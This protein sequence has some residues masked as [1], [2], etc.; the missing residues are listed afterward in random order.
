M[1]LPERII[2]RE[3]EV[4]GLGAILSK[5]LNVQHQRIEHRERHEQT[6]R[7]VAAET[8]L[9]RGSVDSMMSPPD[10]P[11]MPPGPPP[12]P[13]PPGPRHP[14]STPSRGPQGDMGPHGPP[15][16]QGPQGPQGPPGAPGIGMQGPP[17]PP[18]PPTPGT[19]SDQ[20]VAA[21][22]HSSKLQEDRMLAAL[23]AQHAHFIEQ[24]K[25]LEARM[26]L[27]EDI[28]MRATA[29]TTTEII[30]EQ[31][32]GPPTHVHPVIA[33]PENDVQTQLGGV[34]VDMHRTLS[35]H[36]ARQAGDMR[37]FMKQWLKEASMWK[38]PPQH[39]PLTPLTPGSS[40]GDRKP[41]S[42]T[43]SLATQ[44]ARNAETHTSH[45]SSRRERSRSPQRVTDSAATTT[46]VA[47]QRVAPARVTKP[48]AI[49]AP[50]PR[51]Y[52]PPVRAEVAAED[53]PPPPPGR[54]RKEPE[55]EAPRVARPRAIA[56]AAPKSV[57]APPRAP[58][59]P[60]L[61]PPPAP[62]KRRP[63]ETAPVTEPLPRKR[64][65]TSTAIDEPLRR[66]QPP[67]RHARFTVASA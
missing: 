4:A 20:L 51:N 37:D 33:E 2:I 6:V 31:I 44:A 21:L 34:V 49:A 17:G 56:K 5:S 54:K 25:G 40:S 1:Q 18:G 46:A 62:K 11:S 24:Q 36:A 26:K 14:P 48:K 27:Q 58:A 3:M 66:R 32:L 10:P 45:E 13:G 38:A 60:V 67:R 15:G 29:P 28:Y 42:S 23:Q 64:K 8:G 47:T 63:L 65:S 43:Q 52:A 55:K 35:E 53:A 30:R 22:A 12:P 16:D 57:L 9:P 50:K 61:E 59:A 19:A 7:E 41:S 39:V